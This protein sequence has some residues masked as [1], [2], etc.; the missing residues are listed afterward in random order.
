[1]G[2]K[3]IPDQVTASLLE[4]GEIHLE[5]FDGDGHELTVALQDVIQLADILED[6]IDCLRVDGKAVTFVE[7]VLPRAEVA[8]SILRK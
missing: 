3:F 6:V 2:K 4:N 5:M 1:M 7:P 8:M